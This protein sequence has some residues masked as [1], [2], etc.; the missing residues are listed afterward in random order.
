MLGMLSPLVKLQKGFTFR[1]WV[2]LP[3]ARSLVLGCALK[4]SNSGISRVTRSSERCRAT[5]DGSL[6]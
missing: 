2:F 6:R 1:Q 4:T 3:M 5:L